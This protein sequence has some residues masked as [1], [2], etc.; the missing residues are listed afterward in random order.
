MIVAALILLVVMMIALVLRFVIPELIYALRSAIVRV[1]V[2][3][4]I[5]ARQKGEDVQGRLPSLLLRDYRYECATARDEYV[6]ERISKL[7]ELFYDLTW[8]REPHAAPGQH[9]D[10]QVC[11]VELGGIAANLGKEIRPNTLYNDAVMDAHI[12]LRHVANHAARGQDVELGAT[13]SD[14]EKWFVEHPTSI[15]QIN[16]ILSSAALA[17]VYRLRTQRTEA[18]KRA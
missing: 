16:E 8:H 3:E 14:L 17:M 11:I 9:R 10:P 18:K 15:R 6:V 5:L 13:S 12:L 4:A 1:R 2:T 7:R